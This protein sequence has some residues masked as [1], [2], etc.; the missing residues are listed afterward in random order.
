MLAWWRTCKA[1]PAFFPEYGLYQENSKQRGFQYIYFSEAPTTP[2]PP[3]LPPLANFL[4]LSIYSLN[5]L[6]SFYDCELCKIVWQG[7]HPV[8]L[9]KF[10]DSPWLFGTQVPWLSQTLA[11]NEL[12]G[13]IIFP[14]SNSKEFKGDSR[15]KFT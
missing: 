3:P 6:L 11:R 7:F 1:L 2:L 8:F 9:G 10:P 4:D 14:K 15:R 5:K 13:W 12:Q